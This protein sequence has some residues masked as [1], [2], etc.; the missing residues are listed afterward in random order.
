[1]PTH[2]REKGERKGETERK[3]GDKEKEYEKGG[4]GK[5]LRWCQKMTT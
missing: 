2:N 3:G 4:W 5:K 1:M